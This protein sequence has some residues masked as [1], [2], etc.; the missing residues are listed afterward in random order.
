[1]N[2]LITCVGRRNYIVEYFKEALHGKGLVL[3]ANSFAEASGMA[4]SDKAFVVPTIHDRD[5]IDALLQICIENKVKL[6]ISLFDMDL[7]VL[8]S[9]K[10]EFIKIGTVP[11]VSS[12]R[13]VDICNDKLEALNVAQA[14][15]INSPETFLSLNEVNE[16]LK[17][18]KVKFPLVIKPRWGTGSIG[19]EYAEN[20]SELQT[21]YERTRKKINSTYLK[22]I[23]ENE[24]DILV[25]EKVSGVEYGMDVISDLGGNYVTCFVKRKLAMRSG[26]TDRAVTVYSDQMNKIGTR[27]AKLLRH[28]GNLDVDIIVD[29]EKIYL[30]DM[31]ARIGGG[32]PFSHVAGANLPAA[33]IAWVRGEDPQKEW[34]EIQQNVLAVKGIELYVVDKKLIRSKSIILS[35]SE[36]NRIEKR[37]N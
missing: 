33:L 26:E 13:V 3:T 15:G 20:N 21:L 16:G 1:M 17:R 31:N 8:A 2:I 6:L 18:G 9:H 37:A 35:E 5:Y 32:Y 12:K 10:E 34:L 11:I 27:L 28:I 30:I 29:Q 4:A 25:Q 23:S 24:N 19:I 22:Q 7:P 36:E 14:V